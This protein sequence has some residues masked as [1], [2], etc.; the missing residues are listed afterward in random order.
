MPHGEVPGM[1]GRQRGEGRAWPRAFIGVSSGRKGQGSIGML[2]K[3]TR[4]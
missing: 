4:R 2:S 3:F 1:V